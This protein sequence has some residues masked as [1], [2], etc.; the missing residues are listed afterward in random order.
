MQHQ[1][2]NVLWKLLHSSDSY[3]TKAPDEIITH[4]STND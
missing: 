2:Q 1:N 4:T 3:V